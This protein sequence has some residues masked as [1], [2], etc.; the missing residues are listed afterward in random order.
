M[1]KRFWLQE[2]AGGAGGGANGSG[3]AA[4]NGAAGGNGNAAAGEEG[5]GKND[6]VP[7]YETWIKDQPKEVV[8]MLDVHVKGLK[9]ALESERGIREDT[10]KKL[11]DLA[12][13]AEK[14]SEAQ[15]KLTEMADQFAAA[16]RKADFFE[17]AHKAGIANLKLAYVVAT[18]ESLID[19]K[20]RVNFDEMKKIYPELFGK[21][22]T[23]EGNAGNGTEGQNNG[24]VTMDSII[25]SKVNK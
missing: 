1:F 9:T 6:Q 23:P 25:R 16:D 22:I 24:A 4:N 12:K 20:G 8:G 2:E 10:E 17:E 15:Q 3:A 13:T 14:G 5:K 7:V 19:S 11:R 18:T 21:T